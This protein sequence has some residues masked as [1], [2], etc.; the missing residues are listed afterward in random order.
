MEDVGRHYRERLGIDDPHL[1]GEGIVQGLAAALVPDRLGTPAAA[2]R[3]PRTTAARR[4]P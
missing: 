4:R 3:E 2:R 1:S